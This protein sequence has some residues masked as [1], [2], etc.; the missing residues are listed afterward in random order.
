M[1]TVI[2]HIFTWILL[3][4]T[5]SFLPGAE[6]RFAARGYGAE[7]KFAAEGYGVEQTFMSAVRAR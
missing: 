3:L 5:G 1:S 6:G 7:G 2:L 4:L